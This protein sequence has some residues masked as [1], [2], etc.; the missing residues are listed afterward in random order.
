MFEF[1]FWKKETEKNRP[2]VKGY[3]IGWISVNYDYSLATYYRFYNDNPYVASV[4]ERLRRDIGAHWFEIR[5]NNKLNKKAMQQWSEIL[6]RTKLTPRWLIKRI[7]RDYE[8]TGNAYVYLAKDGT[9]V[10]AVQILDPRF[11]TPIANEFGV[12]LGYA[13]AVQTT[14]YFTA[15]EVLH[16]KDD[17]DTNNEI[18]GRSKLRSLIVDIETDKQARDSNYAFFKNNQ[19][20]SSFIILDSEMELPT[21]EDDFKELKREL[22]ELFESNGSGGINNHRSVV[23]QWVKEVINTQSKI[24]DAEF[25]NL[26]R[27]TL[28]LVCSIFG[29]NKD[30][31]GFTDT[32]NRAVSTAQSDNYY[33]LVEDKE[34]F[35][36]EFL[37]SVIKEVIGEQFSYHTLQDNLRTL[38][39]KWEIAEKLYNA[40]IITR[41]EAREI[42][43]YEEHEDGELFKGGASVKDKEQVEENT[44]NETDQQ[45]QQDQNEDDEQD[46]NKGEQED[47]K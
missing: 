3:G 18:V 5:T 25:L 41:N 17:T 15:D 14:Q 7:V 24:S 36:D 23:V 39:I 42:I 29:V 21:N 27:F 30:I 12:V 1:L 46:D 40:E 22:K 13:Y 37:T 33:M 20:P 45:D 31:L 34:E 28:E 19:T 10:E 4:I 2:K 11:V 26:R 47:N 35:L 6:N 43:Q 16:L 38:R 8:L 44:K 9:K 32:S